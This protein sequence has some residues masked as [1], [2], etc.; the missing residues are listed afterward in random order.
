MMI[1]IKNS[2]ILEAL[3]TQGSSKE[4]VEEFVTVNEFFDSEYT[5]VDTAEASDIYD[6]LNK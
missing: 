4:I 5:Y 6:V 1:K 2:V 3:I